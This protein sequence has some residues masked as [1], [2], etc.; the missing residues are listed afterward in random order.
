MLDYAIIVEK[1]NPE[2]N[3]ALHLL[4]MDFVPHL[5]HDG[6]FGKCIKFKTLIN[7]IPYII[8]PILTGLVSSIKIYT[9]QWQRRFRMAT[10]IVH[11][12]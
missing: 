5:V 3:P 11:L 10:V 6:R 12:G 2:F 4:K 7:G 1:E 9:I 8:R